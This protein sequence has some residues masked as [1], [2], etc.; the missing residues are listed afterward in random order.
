M[1]VRTATVRAQRRS[2]SRMSRR[3]NQAVLSA[4]GAQVALS[5]PPLQPKDSESTRQPP[6]QKSS[7]HAVL[8][9]T[10]RSAL[11]RIAAHPS[12]T[13]YQRRVYRTLLS[14]PRG[15]WTT[16]AILSAH[17]SSSARAIGNAMR[18]NPFSPDVPCHRVLATD[19]T[20]GGYKGAWG[21]GGT[22]AEEKTKLLRG[23]GIAFDDKGRAEGEAFRDFVDMGMLQGKT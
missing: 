12:L 16:Y 5:R 13:P 19:R 3:K 10:T 22:Y 7:N 2:S 6:S 1:G 18:A 20:I 21:N 4:T 15:R 14:V 17:L 11:R 9:D 8:D 23:E